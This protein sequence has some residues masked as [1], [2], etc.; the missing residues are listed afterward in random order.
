MQIL[1]FKLIITN[2]R[3]FSWYVLIL[4]LESE[5]KHEL[6]FNLYV[7]SEEGL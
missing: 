6:A 3:I 7:K 2:S 4:L 5:D 1:I